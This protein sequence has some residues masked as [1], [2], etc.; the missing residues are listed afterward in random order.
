VGEDDFRWQ[1]HNSNEEMEV[2]ALHRGPSRLARFLA[3][4]SNVSCGDGETGI[5]YD[6]YEWNPA[7]A[8]RLQNI[9]ERNGAKSRGDFAEYAPIG[10]LETQGPKITLP[11][12]WWS[13]LD[14]SVDAVLCSVD[15]YDVSGDRV[16]F[17]GTQTNRPDLQTVARVVQYA[18]D[19]DYRAVRGYS[20]SA[21]IA[22]KLVEL[23]PSSVIGNIFGEKYPPIRGDLQTIQIEGDDVLRFFLE[24]QNGK[25]V[26]TRFQVNP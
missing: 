18:K 14:L 1:V 25:W 16:R 22:R 10:K 8:G 4:S 5:A 13:A 26:V 2:Y 20:A 19:H 12:C 23:M 21:E 24:E 11:Y 3:R 6:A 15:T 9:L 7:S 17:V